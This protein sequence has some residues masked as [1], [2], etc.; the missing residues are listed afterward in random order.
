MS[1]PS[2]EAIVVCDASPLILLA[3]IDCLDCLLRLADEVWIPEP[4][5][6]EAVVRVDFARHPE[7]RT[8]Q[9]LFAACVRSANPTL[10]DKFETQVD[11]GEAAA[12]AIVSENPQACLLIDDL[13]GRLIAHRN[14]WTYTGTLGW[15]TR[16]KQA[17]V[18]AELR[19]LF[20]KLIEAGWFIDPSLLQQTLQNVGE[21]PL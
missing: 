7:A 11:P 13:R 18:I 1:S 6:D 14:G 3:K 2:T 8:I 15:L 10:Q 19:P 4:V 5:W 20:S 12:L 9:G 16:A 17:G 21:L